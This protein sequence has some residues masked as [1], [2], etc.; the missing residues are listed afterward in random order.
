MAAGWS[1]IRDRCFSILYRIDACV[2][3]VVE[4]DGTLAIV[5]QYPLSDRCLCNQVLDTVAEGVQEVSVSSIG[6]MPV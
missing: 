4:V 3:T 1:E 2:T 6:S 5:F